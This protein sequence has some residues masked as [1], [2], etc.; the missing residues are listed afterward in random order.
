MKSVIILLELILP[1]SFSI[2]NSLS[3]LAELL[4]TDS[5][6]WNST[7][8]DSSYG[9]LSYEVNTSPQPP[10]PI[11]AV[12]EAELDEVY[13][14]QNVRS[15][16]IVRAIKDAEREVEHVIKQLE[17]KRSNGERSDSP[18]EE[19]FLALDDD[20]SEIIADVHDLAKFPQLNY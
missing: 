1:L 16:S 13:T 15:T 9:L 20:L 11:L 7:G 18:E 19:E 12:L 17:N 6:S 8:S 3:H 14:F 4:L 2:S 5:Q 10:H